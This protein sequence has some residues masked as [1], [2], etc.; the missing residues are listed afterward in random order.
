MKL[1][2][3]RRIFEQDYEPNFRNLVRTLSVSINYGI[4]VV[5]EALNK[6]ISLE[7][8]IQCT[9]RDVTFKVNSQGIPAS[10][11][12]FSIETTGQIEGILVLKA[13]NQTNS[14]TYPSGAIF[15]SYTQNNNIITITHA[16]GLQSDNLYKLRVVAFG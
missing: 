6:K 12:A 2:G 9:L 10:I 1:P 7:D 8:N 16:T 4:E 3:F 13:E 15:L 14:S 11:T 5:Y